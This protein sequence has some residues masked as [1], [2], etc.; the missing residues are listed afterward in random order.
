MPHHG[1]PCLQQN[2]LNSLLTSSLAVPSPPAGNVEVVCLISV[3]VPALSFSLPRPP[4]QP[5]RRLPTAR[6][7]I[8]MYDKCRVCRQA[9]LVSALPLWGPGL[10]Y[11]WK[12]IYRCEERRKKCQ[13]GKGENDSYF[14]APLACGFLK[15]S[16]GRGA[17]GSDSSE[18]A[19]FHVWYILQACA[20]WVRCATNI[21]I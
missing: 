17:N 9:N 16:S 7:P 18:L 21:R 11:H 14:P 15:L 8:S 19:C 6:R 5:A 3:S 10:R 2:D 13:F 12:I 1:R 20:V 4:S